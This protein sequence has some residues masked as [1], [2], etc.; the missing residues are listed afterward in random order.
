M[1]DPRLDDLQRRLE[2][3]FKRNN[4]TMPKPMTAEE[5]EAMKKADWQYLV[6]G[7]QQLSRGFFG[8]RLSL[9]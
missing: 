6:E 2:D 7:M 1:T 4:L 5:Q 3:A 8:A 9:T